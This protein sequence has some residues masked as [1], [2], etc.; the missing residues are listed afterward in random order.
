MSLFMAQ[1]P[2]VETA[3]TARMARAAVEKLLFL[4]MIDMGP[5][6]GKCPGEGT[7][8]GRTVSSTD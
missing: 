7:R 5:S 6:P 8:K 4:V 2:S 1:P 3:A